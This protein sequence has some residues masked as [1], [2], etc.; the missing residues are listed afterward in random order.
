MYEYLING[1]CYAALK[2]GLILSP[3]SQRYPQG[4]KKLRVEYFF[5]RFAVLSPWWERKKVS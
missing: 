3:D 4:V 5:S 2:I 1:R